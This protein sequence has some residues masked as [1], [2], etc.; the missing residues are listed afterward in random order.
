MRST[1]SVNHIVPG[2]QCLDVY[3]SASLTRSI[4]RKN[5]NAGVYSPFHV[6]SNCYRFAPHNS[7]STSPIFS[8]TILPQQQ[9][10]H[11]KLTKESDCGNEYFP[12]K[13]FLSLN[14]SAPR[15][16]E[17]RRREVCL[18]LKL[19]SGHGVTTACD[20]REHVHCLQIHCCFQIF[21]L[22]QARVPGSRSGSCCGE[23]AR[24]RER[25]RERAKGGARAE[26]SGNL[27]VP[28]RR[29]T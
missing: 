29:F 12:V 11:N 7:F 10:S 20:A 25:E 13:G 8:P 3:D 6:G 9:K 18:Y 19:L 27:M 24:E 4:L 23:G 2:R 16:I 1:I 22:A 21:S 15:Q 28:F 14:I 26:S 5:K 17:R